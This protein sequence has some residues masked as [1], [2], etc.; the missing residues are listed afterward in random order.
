ML[1]GKF[2]SGF[3]MINSPSSMTEFLPYPLPESPVNEEDWN[4]PSLFS[5]ELTQEKTQDFRIP[6]TYGVNHL[7]AYAIPV[8]CKFSLTS[9]GE[10]SPLP[11]KISAYKEDKI[12]GEAKNIIK[13]C[14]VT[15]EVLHKNFTLKIQ[16]SQNEVSPTTTYAIVFDKQVIV[17]NI[18]VGSKANILSLF[19]EL[20]YGNERPYR[21]RKDLINLIQKA[22]W[23]S[24]FKSHIP[25]K[26][27]LNYNLKDLLRNGKNQSLSKRHSRVDSEEDQVSEN[28]AVVIFSPSPFSEV[29]ERPYF[30]SP[31]ELEGYEQVFFPIQNE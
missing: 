8:I 10:E 31:Q 13:S 23:Y 26:K 2:F 9:F 24:S 17:Q 28:S 25:P 29:V 4:T 20:F 7:V 6:V 1:Q 5:I 27:P 18:V 16:F 19:R 22:Y 15:K 30:F 12:I 11:I 21:P 14:I 3:T